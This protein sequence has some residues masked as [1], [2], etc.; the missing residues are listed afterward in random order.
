MKKLDIFVAF[1]LAVAG[2]NWGLVGLFDFNIVE[3]I[4]RSAKIDKIVYV[5]TGLAGVYQIFAW[6]AICKRCRQK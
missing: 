3:F 6:K 5:L 1:L 4:F 2:I